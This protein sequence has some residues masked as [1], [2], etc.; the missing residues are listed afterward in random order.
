M[1]LKPNL[2]DERGAVIVWFA[3]LLIALVAI[4][5]LAVDVGF[6]MATRNE[7]QNV[8]DSAALAGARQLGKIYQAMGSDVQDGYVLTG[9]DK[10]LIVTTV[11]DVADENTAG[12]VAEIK[13]KPE[14]V[15]VGVW[16]NH[17]FDGTAGLPNANAVRVITRRDGTANDSVTTFFASMWK[18]SYDLNAFATAALTGKGTAEPGELELPVGIDEH[19]FMP[20]GQCGQVIKFSPT[21]DPDACAGWTTFEYAPSNDP[22]I[23]KLLDEDPSYPSPEVVTD[24]SLFEFIGGDLSV[25]TFD[26]LLTAFQRNGYDVDSAGNPILDLSGEPMADATGTGSEVP[27]TDEAGERLLYPDGTE[28]NDHRWETTVVVYEAN[29]CGNP[30]Q[31]MLIKGFARIT[32]TDVQGPP[33]KLIQGIIECNL[34][35]V[36]DTRGGGGDFGIF[37][38]IPGLVE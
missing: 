21:T 15:E 23:R 29:E 5:A 28:R 14:D 3:F 4:S 27:L 25:P 12:G 37:G 22:T 34:V 6:M 24:D 38:S 32:I 10:S 2:A 18:E 1:T 31:Q 17:S 33:N 16:E 13:V 9:A 8:A 36:G 19:Y 35:D 7:L 11:L 30:N 20:G 26:N